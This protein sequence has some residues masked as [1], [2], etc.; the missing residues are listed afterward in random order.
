MK[1]GRVVSYLTLNNDRVVMQRWMTSTQLLCWDACSAID[2]LG[3]NIAG[4]TQNSNLV[5]VFELCAH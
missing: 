2:P 3:A 4:L 1:A 5:T